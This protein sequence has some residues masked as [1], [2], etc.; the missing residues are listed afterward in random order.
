[1]TKKIDS[2]NPLVT[3]VPHQRTYKSKMVAIINPQPTVTI[4]SLL[5]DDTK[6][7]YDVSYNIISY[8]CGGMAG[9][10][11]FTKYVWNFLKEEL[12]FLMLGVS[13]DEYNLGKIVNTLMDL[14]KEL[15]EDYAEEHSEQHD[16]NPHVSQVITICEEDE[17]PCAV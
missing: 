7:G 16:D 10:D 9:D 8:L 13:E 1:M 15:S 5:D 17:D 14:I 12:G 6:V 3:L 4:Y 2:A 11:D